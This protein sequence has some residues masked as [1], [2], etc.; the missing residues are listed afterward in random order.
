MRPR[1]LIVNR[2][3]DTDGMIAF[4]EEMIVKLM[5]DSYE[6]GLEEGRNKALADE[7]VKMTMLQMNIDDIEVKE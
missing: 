3:P 2:M 7:F 6:A 4:T 5:T 1:V